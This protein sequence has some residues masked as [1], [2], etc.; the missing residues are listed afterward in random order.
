MRDLRPSEVTTSGA[1]RS[2]HRPAAP[3]GAGW[4]PD[5]YERHRPERT[6]LY[7]L[8]QQHSATFLAQAEAAAGAD[9]PK[10]VTDEFKGLPRIQGPSSNGSACTQR[11][12]V[13][14]V[15]FRGLDPQLQRRLERGVPDQ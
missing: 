1:S 15:Q 12:E 6:A 3:A 5:H 2:S 10:F 9:L 13:D 8:V 14:L 11:L 7:R 4:R